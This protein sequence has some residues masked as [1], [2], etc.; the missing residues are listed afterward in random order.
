MPPIILAFV[1]LCVATP[2]YAEWTRAGSASE[3]YTQYID[4]SSIRR[5]STVVKVWVLYDFHKPQTDGPYGSAYLSVKAQEQLDCTNELSL[6][7][8]ISFHS[9]HMGAGQVLHTHSP[10]DQWTPVPPDSMIANLW[11]V[12]CRKP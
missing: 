11:N 10:K 1:L 6:S 8:Y 7:L 2:A 9:G 3:G 4:E 12:L 5:N